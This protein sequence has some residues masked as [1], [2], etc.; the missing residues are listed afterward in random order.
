MIR[1]CSESRLQRHRKSSTPRKAKRFLRPTLWLAALLPLAM[2]VPALAHGEGETESGFLETF[3]QDYDRAAKKIIDLAEAVPADKYS[4]RP[5]AGVRSVSESLM[6]VA[7]THFALSKALGHAKPQGIGDDLE[8]ITEKDKVI[9]I[10]KQAIEHARQAA[11]AASQGDLNRK[12]EVFGFKMA[13]RS[14]LFIMSGHQHEHLGQAI[15][16]ARM[17]GIVPPWSADRDGD[18]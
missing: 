15:A 11:D 13:A 6:H 1:T 17:N 7:G 3:L 18:G 10:L 12:V 4:W 14:I 5:A 9:E 8:K 16:Y 2:T